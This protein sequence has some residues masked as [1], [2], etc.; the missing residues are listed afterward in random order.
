MS[1]KLYTLENE[2]ISESEIVPDNFTGIIKW[3]HLKVWYL[4]GNF[5]RADG[6][7]IERLTGT[8]EWYLNGER[9]RLDG[10]AFEGW[11]GHKTYFINGEE[12]TEQEHKLLVNI[13]KLKGLLWI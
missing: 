10:P 4:E 8:K 9:H 13:M 6:P 2:F 11:D 1:C 7:A 5:H 12:I 3:N